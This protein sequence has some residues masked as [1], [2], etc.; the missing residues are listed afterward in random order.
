MLSNTPTAEQL[1]RANA[2][3]GVK[4]STTSGSGGGGSGS[5]ESSTTPNTTSSVIF[6]PVRAADV[7]PYVQRDSYEHFLFIREFMSIAGR[8]WSPTILTYFFFASFLIVSFYFLASLYANYSDF[9]DW[10]YYAI[11]MSIRMYVLV[12]YPITSLAHANAYVYALQEQFLVAAPEDFAVLGGREEWLSYLERVPAVWT[13][14]GVWITWDRLTGLLWTS[15][16]GFGAIVISIAS[17]D[18]STK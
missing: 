15:V 14:Y 18:A 13:V 4:Q 1:L 8:M 2:A 3:R 7:V 6:K 10:V 9:W 16:A 11:W 12:I 17:A 5:V